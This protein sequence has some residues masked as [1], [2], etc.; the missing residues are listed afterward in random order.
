LVEKLRGRAS[1]RYAWFK[2][3]TTNVEISKG[4]I[5][6]NLR[7]YDTWEKTALSMISNTEKLDYRKVVFSLHGKASAQRE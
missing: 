3:L 6:E 7:K 5:L 1:I 2:N 4:K